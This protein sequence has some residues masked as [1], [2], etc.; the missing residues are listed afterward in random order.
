MEELV[1][2]KK[3]LTFSRTCCTIASWMCNPETGIIA[4]EL[5]S[6]TRVCSAMTVLWKIAH[7][8]TTV[9]RPKIQWCAETESPECNT[10]GF[11]IKTKTAVFSKTD[12]LELRFNHFDKPVCSDSYSYHHITI[13][14]KKN[15]DR[16][17]K[18]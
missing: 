18:A 9:Q 17:V 11:R 8:F 7:M 16:D 13:Y 10:T 3:N 1:V 5:R 2:Q 4:S 6:Y 12:P 15:F 14:T